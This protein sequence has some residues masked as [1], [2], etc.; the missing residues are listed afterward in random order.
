MKVAVCVSGLPRGDYHKNIS[1]LKEYFPYDFFYGTWSD[2]EIAL[3]HV[4]F[5]E[6]PNISYNPGF[7]F[8]GNPP[9]TYKEKGEYHKAK[10]KPKLWLHRTKQIL[11]HAYMMEMI[12]SEYDMI[13]RCRFDT[14]INKQ[15]PTETITT[16]LKNAY[17][18][19]RSVG[20]FTPKRQ[21][22]KF[23]TTFRK[24][25]LKHNRSVEM[26][27]DHMIFHRRDMFDTKLVWNL[28]AK[29]ELVAAEYGWYQILSKPYTEDIFKP[30]HDT[31]I[32]FCGIGE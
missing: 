1:E 26:H 6:Q 12:P 20:F 2:A 18:N 17:Q 9:Y 23:L 25:P 10:Q 13:I 4:Y 15:Q 31:Y 24:L 27:S 7:E 32:G 19:R 21:T 28:H 22:E 29:S 14:V 30:N 16:I 11:L 3:P 8:I 5:F